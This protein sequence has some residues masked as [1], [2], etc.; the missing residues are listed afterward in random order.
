M[1][2]KNLIAKIYLF[3]NLQQEIQDKL[4]AI[5]IP[6]HFIADQVIYSEGKPA[7]AIFII[8]NGWVKASRMSRQGC[9]QA[10]L[11]FTFGWRHWQCNRIFQITVSRYRNS[12]QESR[13]ICHSR[14]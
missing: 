6:R 7:E 2:L 13:F 8:E 1:S 12:T 11:F 4:L 3:K 5:A 14:C 9:E 10:L